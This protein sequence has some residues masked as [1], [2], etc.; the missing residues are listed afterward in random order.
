MQTLLVR[1]GKCNNTLFFSLIYLSWYYLVANYGNVLSLVVPVWP[2]PLSVFVNSVTALLAQLFLSYRTWR[3]TNVYV[4]ACLVP[5]CLASFVGGILCGVK[6][7]VY[8]KNATAMPLVNTYLSTWLSLEVVAD[9]VITGS[10]IY[11]LNKSRSGLQELDTVVNRLIRTA[12]Q[13]GNFRVRVLT[14]RR[15]ESSLGLFSGIFAI[16]TL[17]FYLARQDTELWAFF[18]LPISRLYTNTLMDSLLCREG[19]RGIMKP[20]EGFA[21]GTKIDI[22]AAVEVHE[23]VDPRMSRTMSPF[24]QFRA[25]SRSY[26]DNE[27]L[28]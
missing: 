24:P 20:S 13:T 22:R 26:A 28:T 1:R 9:I 27:E 16:L 8:V 12:I 23:R 2:Y 7:W 10:L 11:A 15:T 6:A 25:P 5:L 14:R 3:L 18:G 17:V 19:L 21:T 4:F